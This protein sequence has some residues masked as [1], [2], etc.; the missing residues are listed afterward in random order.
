MFLIK[1]SA[2]LQFQNGLN[3]ASCAILFHGEVRQEETYILGGEGASAR[4]SGKRHYFFL[5]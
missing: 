1:I 4:S 5:Y 3:L 2:C